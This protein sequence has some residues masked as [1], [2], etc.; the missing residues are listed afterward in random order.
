MFSSYFSAEGYDFLK[1]NI[2]GLRQILLL[3]L[4]HFARNN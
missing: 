4:F 3:E 1:L 2:Q